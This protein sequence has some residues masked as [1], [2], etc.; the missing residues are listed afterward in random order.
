MWRTR[1]LVAPGIILICL[2]AGLGQRSRLQRPEIPTVNFCE[3]TSHPEKY[4]DKL[5]RTEASY[6]A[7]WESSL[8]YNEACAEGRHIHNAPDCPDDS[9]RC[10]KR[11]AS[12]WRKLD[13]YMRSKEDDSGNT[14]SRVK[15]VFIGRLVGPGEYGHLNGFRY[16]FRIKAVESASAIP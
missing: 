4:T 6:L 10:L 14:I 13:P 1:L 5:V 9:K 3:L 8:L 15:A 2:L 11:F 7:W 12:E 16:E